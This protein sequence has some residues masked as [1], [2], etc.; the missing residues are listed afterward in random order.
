MLTQLALVFTGSFGLAQS[1]AAL[2]HVAVRNG[3]YELATG[4]DIRGVVLL[5]QVP[6]V[7]N[8]DREKEWPPEVY[9]AFHE[10]P[11]IDAASIRMRWANLEPADEKFDWYAIDRLLAEVRRYNAE[12]PGARRTLHIRVLGGDHVPRW[13]EQAGVRFYD[14]FHLLGKARRK[15]ALRLPMPYDNPEFLRQLRQVYR[16]FYNRYGNEPLVAV[17]HGTWSAGPWDEIFHPMGDQPMPPDYTQ[18]KFL[19]GMVEQ[20]DVL[21]EEFC[22]KGKV[23]ELPYSGKYPQKDQI[24]ITGRLTARAV[25]RLGRNSPFLIFQSNGWGTTSTGQPAVSWGHEWDFNETYGQVNLAL[26]ALGTNAGGGWWPQGDWLPLVRLA[27]DYE[28]PYVE[29]YPPD[30]MPLDVKHNMV[31]AFTGVNG[32]RNWLKENCRL[33]FVREGTV[34]LRFQGPGAPKPVLRLLV[35]ADAPASTWVRFR[36]RT[37][38]VGGAWSEWQPRERVPD[39]PAGNEAEL[40]AVLHTDDGRLTPRLVEMSPAWA[41]Y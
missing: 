25:E 7:G 8:Y 15:T 6:E 37:R 24:D 35:A 12:H 3:G 38:T 34:R 33:S 4:P 10:V 21:I 28:I 1:P 30:F 39:L 14:T 31:E 13:F 41:Q 36:A 20:L 29:L 27:K 2:E 16:A 22:L 23:A 11:W 18:E 5:R 40:E 19:R 17:Y 9:G 32:Y 26:Q